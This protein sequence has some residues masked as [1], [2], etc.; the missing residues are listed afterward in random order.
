MST[1]T[2]LR[3][4]AHGEPPPRRHARRPRRSVGAAITGALGEL[5]ITAGVLLALFVVWQLWWT[6]VEG[7][8][9]AEQA[10]EQFETDIPE[11]PDTVGQPRTG[12]PPEEV[13]PGEGEVFG[14][15]YVPD[16]GADYRMPLAEGVDL[17][18]VL[19]DGRVGHYPETAMPGQVGN[20][21]MAGHRQTYG[22]PFYAVDTLDEGD[23][24]VV[25]TAQAWYVY[26]VT[27]HEI[28]RPDQVEVIAPVPGD[29]GADPTEAM[30]TMTSCH[31]LWSTAERYI[32][33]AQLDYWLPLDEGY[34]AELEGAP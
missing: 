28:V 20:F 21:A 10:I 19:N 9:S 1:L 23:P 33:H 34:P 14:T 3:H 6:D 22:K 26:T 27:S 5:L 30:L 24:V 11:V 15:L 16:W 2:D 32:V 18:T 7:E 13:A 4:D 12:P 29:P 25:Q 8:R 31:P 17:A